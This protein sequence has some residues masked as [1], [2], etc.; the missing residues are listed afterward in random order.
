MRKY[1]RPVVHYEPTDGDRA[2]AARWRK[3]GSLAKA[4]SHYRDFARAGP[5][6]ADA[7]LPVFDEDEGHQEE[8]RLMLLTRP[9]AQVVL[10]CEKMHVLSALDEWVGPRLP[11]VAHAARAA[12]SWIPPL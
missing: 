10:V 9:D 11:S 12:L 1:G 2:R 4:W 8:E 3:E 5:W 7:E 6:A